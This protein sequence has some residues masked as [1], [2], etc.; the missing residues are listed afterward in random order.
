M[1]GRFSRTSP[2]ACYRAAVIGRRGTTNAVL[3]G[4][5]KISIKCLAL[6]DTYIDFI[7]GALKLFS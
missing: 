3:D 6:K 5:S 4:E 2:D 1:A 7:L